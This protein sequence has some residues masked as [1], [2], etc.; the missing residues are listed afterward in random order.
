MQLRQTDRWDPEFFGPWPA[1]RNRLH[2][3]EP[4]D[5]AESLEDLARFFAPGSPFARHNEWRAFSVWRDGELQG[6]LVASRPK[7][8]EARRFA[9]VGFFECVR[10]SEA[11]R[12]LFDAA[13][14]WARERGFAEIRGPIQGNFF[15]SYKLRLP[16]GGEPFYGEPLCPD[17]YHKLFEEQGFSLSGKWDTL[18][19][20]YEDS[21]EVSEQIIRRFHASA[22]SSGLEIRPVDPRRWREELRLIHGL[23]MDSYAAMPDFM[24]ISF[25]EFHHFY[26][27]FK[28]LILPDLSLFV[29]HEG[30]TL[31][32]MIAYFDP[33]RIVHE[34]QERHAQSRNPLWKLW[35]LI[36]LK[37][38][39]QR[40]L[41]VYIGKTKDSD[42]VKGVAGALL[43][44]L[45]MAIRKHRQGYLACYLAE[46]SPSY[47]TLPKRHRHHASY[48]L[49]SKRLAP[50]A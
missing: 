5:L 6:R 47:A 10:D 25:E 32:F 21:V 14:A 17:Y 4:R 12:L 42:R 35:T 1:L 50:E 40:L 48:A 26:D 27:S 3:G 28:H 43:G 13:G 45:M 7:E 15:I 11:A 18:E 38:N 24:P 39:R 2:R 44:R 20:S 49:Y 31:G 34:H 30:K 41:I 29:S 8:W 33:L 9:P 37:R 36:K 23:F 19:A 46:G 16:G 22:G